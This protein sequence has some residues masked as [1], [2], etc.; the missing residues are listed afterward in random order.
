MPVLT[1]PESPTHRLEGTTFTSLATPSR[2]SSDLAV[3]SVE[4]A[5]RTLGTPHSRLRPAEEVFVVLEGEAS[6]R[7][8]GETGDRSSG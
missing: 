4:M 8:G 7:L 6:V 2:G 5:P 3:W 1:T